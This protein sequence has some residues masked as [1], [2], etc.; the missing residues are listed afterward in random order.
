MSALSVLTY[1]SLFPNSVQPRHGIFIAQRLR[2]LCADFDL[3]SRVVAPVP[4]FPWRGDRFGLYGKYAAVP[5]H[6]VLDA[7]PVWHPRYPVLPKVTWPV[8][9][10]FLYRATRGLVAELARSQTIDVIDAHFFYPDGV[11]AVM[12]GRE[13]GIPV[14]V[15]ARGSDISLMPE[16]M[17]PRRWITWAARHADG[18]ITVAAALRDRLVTLGIDADRISVLRNG[19]DLERFHPSTSTDLRERLGLGS[20]ALLSVGNLIELKG[21]HLVIEALRELPETTLMI[22]GEGPERGALERL[23]HRLG[24][25]DRVRFLGLIAQADLPGYYA[26]ADALVLASSREGWANV[27]LEAMACGTPVVATRVWGTPEVVAAPAAGI[28][29]DERSARGVADGV[30]RLLSDPPDPRATRAYAEGFSWYE[31]SQ[32]QYELFNRVKAERVR[33][34]R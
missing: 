22:I 6:E 34:S 9:P 15:S 29:I 31:T 17:L 2:H 8:S 11:A 28:L 14:V 18:L 13:L 26:A 19:V 23:A 12:I 10:W 30:R 32:G 4:W 16:F 3:V 5:H 24:V 33:A 27:L 21:H 25:A 1:T 20:R 7:M